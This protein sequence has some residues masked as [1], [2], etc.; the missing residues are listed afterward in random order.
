M[1]IIS[2]TIAVFWRRPGSN[3]QFQADVARLFPEEP[4]V[5]ALR[6]FRLMFPSDIICSARDENG[7]FIPV[8]AAL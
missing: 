2:N 1:R 3:Q 7:R 4:S 5:F 6:R 8:K